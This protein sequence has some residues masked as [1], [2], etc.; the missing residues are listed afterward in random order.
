MIDKH[1][2]KNLKKATNYNLGLLLIFSS[3]FSVESFEKFDSNEDNVT[4]FCCCCC[5]GG[6][7]R[8]F[9]GGFLFNGAISLIDVI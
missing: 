3:S 2:K 5:G 6:G 9:G 7:G 1:K 4:G 8:Q